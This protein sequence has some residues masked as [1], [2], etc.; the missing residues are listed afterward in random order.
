M[1]FNEENKSFSFLDK[2]EILNSP[3]YDFVD[4]EVS[5]SRDMKLNMR[6]KIVVLVKLDIEGEEKIVLVSYER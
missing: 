3:F 4:F 2:R 1:A 6:L 5:P